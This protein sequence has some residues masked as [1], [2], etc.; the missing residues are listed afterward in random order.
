[1]KM[2]KIHFL[3]SLDDARGAI[4]LAK[5]FSVI[6]L[7]DDIYEVPEEAI[8]VLDKIGISPQILQTEGFDNALETLRAIRGS[9]S[10]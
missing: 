9:S 4:E 3:S 2:I 5:H 10:T 1:M 7:P 8:S 6:C